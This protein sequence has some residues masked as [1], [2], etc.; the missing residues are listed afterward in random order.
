MHFKGQAGGVVVMFVRPTW[1]ACG[2]QVGVL[3]PDLALLIK[4]HCGSIPYKIEE[5]WHRC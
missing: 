2:S 5:H 4:P 1:V 3:G